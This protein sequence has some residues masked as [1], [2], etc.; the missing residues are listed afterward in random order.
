MKQINIF[1]IIKLIIN[2]LL[3]ITNY[4]HLL[5]TY[6]KTHTYINNGLL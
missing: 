2:K 5:I 4:R 3:I 1:V 6:M